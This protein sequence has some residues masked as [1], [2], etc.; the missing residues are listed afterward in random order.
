[1]EIEV[2][3]DRKRE[4]EILLEQSKGYSHSL[5]GDLEILES[6][7]RGLRDEICYAQEAKVELKRDS[8][9]AQLFY[10]QRDFE[11]ERAQLSVDLLACTKELDSSHNELAFSQECSR[12]LVQEL[13]V[14]VE[15][16]RLTSLNVSKVQGDLA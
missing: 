11:S 14:V 4:L 15:N 12:M 1:M 16:G 6:E 8:A 9:R 2:F 7:V 10:A 13:A 3:F 5:F